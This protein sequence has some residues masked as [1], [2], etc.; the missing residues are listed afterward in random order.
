MQVRS[1]M[2]VAALVA[3]VLISSTVTAAASGSGSGNAGPQSTSHARA[4]STGATSSETSFVPITPCRIVD[5]RRAL[6]GA[7]AA[8]STRTFVAAT[9]GQLGLA[10]QGGSGSGCPVSI[11]ATAVQADVVAV[12]ATGSGYLT[13]FPGDAAAPLASWLNFRD[14]KAI[15]N[16]G[17]ITLSGDGGSTFAVKASRSTHVVVDVT[18]Y[19]LPRMWA[20]VSTA[21]A[22]DAGSRVAAVTVAGSGD[23]Q[24]TFDRDVSQCAYAATLTSAGTS[25]TARTLA[26][27][28]VDTVEVRT[29][30]SSG[31]PTSADFML[32]V[33]C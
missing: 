3:A 12:G 13:V 8:R 30:N 9:D 18:G 1:A 33:T 27:I 20:H 32:T 21:G 15:A 31:V 17:T 11:A 6:D 29:I 23:V 19:F 25:V 10:A 7:V 24:V 14:G 22:L 5:T 4:A 16:G 26:F 28:G 2:S